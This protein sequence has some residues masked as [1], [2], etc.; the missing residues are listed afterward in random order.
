MQSPAQSLSSIVAAGVSRRHSIGC[1]VYSANL[2]LTLASHTI[3][4]LFSTVGDRSVYARH[5]VL[6]EFVVCHNSTP[7]RG[8]ILQQPAAPQQSGSAKHIVK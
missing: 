8:T 4:S 6:K 1:V 3:N 7:L 5:Q 2:S